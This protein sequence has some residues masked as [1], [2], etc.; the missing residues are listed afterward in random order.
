[1]GKDK[2]GPQELEAIVAILEATPHITMLRVVRGDA[3]F[4]LARTLP[5]TVVASQQPSEP[6]PNDMVQG[7]AAPVVVKSRTVGKFFRGTTLGGQPLVNLTETVRADSPIGMIEVV[8][9]PVP[10][11]A[12]TSGRVVT[13][14][15]DDGQPVEFGQ[16]LATI[17]PDE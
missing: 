1:M 14:L 4:A 17:Q 8:R 5:E 15:A 12:E 16:P 9:R 11:L 10:V 7:S 13:I 3:E 2:F 6:T